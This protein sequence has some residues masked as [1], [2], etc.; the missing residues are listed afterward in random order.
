MR[1][2]ASARRRQY[3][4]SFRSV[5]DNPGIKGEELT[6]AVLSDA[7]DYTEIAHLEVALA[8]GETCA[9]DPVSKVDHDSRESN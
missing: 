3:W 4:A 8:A 9:L 2:P 5:F 6:S 1:T 7:V